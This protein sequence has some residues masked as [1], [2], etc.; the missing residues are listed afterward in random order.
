MPLSLL[1][2]RLMWMK[3]VG[4]FGAIMWIDNLIIKNP[5]S[6]FLYCKWWTKYFCVRWLFYLYQ[7]QPCLKTETGLPCLGIPSCSVHW[8]YLF[9]SLFVDLDVNNLVN[10]WY[11]VH[12]KCKFCTCMYDL[13]P[14]AC[15]LTTTSLNVLF[16]FSWIPSSLLLPPLISL[17]Y[18]ALL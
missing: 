15:V 10:R 16:L 18:T 12:E 17:F 6:K 5:F 1:W 7:Y 11:N 8:N 3:K 13:Y 9:L 2:S 4:H 14:W